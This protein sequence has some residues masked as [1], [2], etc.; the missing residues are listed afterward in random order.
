M[1]R[2]RYRKL[3]LTTESEV[4]GKYDCYVLEVSPKE[5]RL[6]GCDAV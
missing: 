2:F 5:C 3:R 1:S 4:S 6:L